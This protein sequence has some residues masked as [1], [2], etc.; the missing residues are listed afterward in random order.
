M[1]WAEQFSSPQKIAELVCIARRNQLLERRPLYDLDKLING[2]RR[3][4]QNDAAIFGRICKLA[5][6]A[7]D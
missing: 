4:N 5:P 3:G 2:G 1:R 6:P 7:F